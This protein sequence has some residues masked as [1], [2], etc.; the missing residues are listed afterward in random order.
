[1]NFGERLGMSTSRAPRNRKRQLIWVA[2]IALIGTTLA[3]RVT[4]NG[5]NKFEY[6]QGVYRITACDQWVGIS[7]APTAAWGDGY[8]RIG[9]V[10]FQGLDVAQCPKTSI[11][12]QLFEAGS[13]QPMK[14]FTNLAGTDTG[15]AV[16]LVIAN[17][18]TTAT[19]GDDVTLL[20]PGGVN[21]GY[22]DPSQNIEYDANTAIFTVSFTKPIAKMSLF[23]SLTI[24]SATLP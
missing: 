24:E 13:S 21:I 23:K 16:T 19:A 11:R 8:S 1:M 17:G 6:G 20:N 18:A 3:A 2:V 22:G 12:L 9:N 7:F 15:T 5:N 4:I 14:L 10:T